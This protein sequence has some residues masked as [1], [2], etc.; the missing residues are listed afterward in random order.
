MFV[1]FFQSQFACLWMG[2][3]KMG[4]NRI[5]LFLCIDISMLFLFIA[6]RMNHEYGNSLVRKNPLR[7]CFFH[8]SHPTWAMVSEAP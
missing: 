4:Q 8:I 2:W 7:L 6:N 5:L 3:D 1:G